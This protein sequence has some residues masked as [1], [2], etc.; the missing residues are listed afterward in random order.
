[1]GIGVFLIIVG[2][3]LTFAV[4]RDTAAV[5][6]QIV[7]IILMLAGG[8]IVYFVRNARTIRETVT[9]D[10]LSDPTRPVHIVHEEISDEKP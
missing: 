7:G 6:L 8:A 4:R 3:I 10:D 9:T 1:M 5:D 2:A